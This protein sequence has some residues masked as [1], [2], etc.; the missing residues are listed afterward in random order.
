MSHP[1]E[2][3]FVLFYYGEQDEAAEVAAHLDLCDSC[4]L[5]YQTLQRVL[6]SVD[7][8]AVPERAADFEERVWHT[9]APKLGRRSPGRRFWFGWNLAAVTVAIVLLITTVFFTAPVSRIKA[10]D[11]RE[12]AEA[13]NVR[14]RVLLVAVGSH[15]E[16]SQIIL[17]ELANAK[18]DLRRVDISDERDAASSL[19]DAN[20]LFR[21]TAASMGDQSITALLDDLERVLVEIAHSPSAMPARQ[22]EDLRRQIEDRSLLFKVKVLSSQVENREASLME[23]KSGK[24]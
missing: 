23:S 14:E 8:L 1:T 12:S 20:R 19:L 21:Q 5:T 16:R 15:L 13:A 9:L 6:N 7:C 2:E 3:Q 17:V 24:L 11:P 22:W 18:P 4:R 10:R